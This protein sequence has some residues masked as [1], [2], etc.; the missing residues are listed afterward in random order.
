MSIGKDTHDEDVFCYDNLT[1]K[2]SNE[3]KILGVI[4]DGKLTFQQHIKKI[5]SEAG[6]KL[7]ASLKLCPYIDTNKKKA[8]YTS[9]VISQLNYCPLV[10]MFCPRRSKNLL[11]KVHERALRITYNDQLTD[12]KSLLLSHNEIT[13]H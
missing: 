6:K 13:I 12:F 3:D 8:I 11:N 10:W 5:C 4:I 9:I 7:S 1:L 2:N